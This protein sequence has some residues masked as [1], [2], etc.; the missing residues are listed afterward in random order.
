MKKISEKVKEYIDK[1]KSPQKEIILKVRKIFFKTIRNCEEDFDWGVISLDQGRFYL[2]GLKDK[3]NV[4]FSIKGLS[5]EE[6]NEFEG[7]GKTMRHI[8][9]SDMDGIDEKR[10][11]KLIK[12]AHSKSTSVSCK[13]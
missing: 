4:G 5:K 7:K 8:K 1:Q 3:V 10:L 11:V 6:I 2:V 13:K 9:I 12:L